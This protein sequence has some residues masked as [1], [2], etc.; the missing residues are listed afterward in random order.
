MYYLQDKTNI[1]FVPY[2]ENHFDVLP[3]ND[4]IGDFVVPA[5]EYYLNKIRPYFEYC[6]NKSVLEIGPFNGWHSDEILKTNPTSLTLVEASTPA[7]LHLAAKYK[8]TKNVT[9]LNQDIFKYVRDVR[10]VD[11]VVACGVIYHFHAPF[12]LFEEIVNNLTPNHVIIECPIITAPFVDSNPYLL[13]VPYAEMFNETDNTPGMR[14]SDNRSVGMSVLINPA[15]IIKAFE[16]LG[17]E[18][19][20]TINNSCKGTQSKVNVQIY[21]FKRL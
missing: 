6:Q 1:D 16:N 12:Y 13:T 5:W 20:E 7:S 17:Y 4:A 9:V 11:T 21:A 3:Y 18:L 2:N 10:H 8:D 19:L 14:Y 15:A